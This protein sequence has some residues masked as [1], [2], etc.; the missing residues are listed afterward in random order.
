MAA[1]SICLPDRR[2]CAQQQTK[3]DEHRFKK[4]DKNE[5]VQEI[6]TREYQP[7]RRFE[8][9]GYDIAR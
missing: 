4:K 9:G 2:G 7:E 8:R 3:E 5:N 6:P 1:L